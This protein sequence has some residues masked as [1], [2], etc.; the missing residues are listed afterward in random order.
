M[1]TFLTAIL[2]AGCVSYAR[3]LNEDPMIAKWESHFG[4]YP[5]YP[6][7][8]KGT[9]PLDNVD[10]MENY[11]DSLNWYFNYLFAYVKVV[12]EYAATKGYTPPRTTPI[13]KLITLP[14]LNKIPSF[15][16]KSLNT[17][18]HEFEQELTNYII[19]LKSLAKDDREDIK[20]VTHYQKYLCIY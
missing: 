20:N 10:D 17:E 19:K 16:S 5:E 9:D 7:I 18:G 11:V 6:H 14:S 13:C 1:V 8:I 15:N 3:P 4:P 12:N 2:V